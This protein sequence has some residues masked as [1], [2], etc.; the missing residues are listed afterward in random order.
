[1]RRALAL[2]GAKYAIVSLWDVPALASMLLMDFFF[3][4]YDEGIDPHL[5]LRQAQNRVRK[6]SISELRRS[7]LGN[8]IIAELTD[9]GQI[10]S[11]PH[12]D[13]QPLKSPYFWGAW[14]CQG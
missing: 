5:A 14:I 6:I 7:S 9:S 11:Q 8:D 1:L 2:A 10:H 12:D 13:F 4:A 3:D